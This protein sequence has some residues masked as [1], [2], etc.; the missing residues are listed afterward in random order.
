MMKKSSCGLLFGLWVVLSSAL[1]TLF[2]E[3][4]F[5]QTPY[6]PRI[7]GVSFSEIASWQA[8]YGGGFR[9]CYPATAPACIVPTEDQVPCK[10]RKAKT[11]AKQK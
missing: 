11:R 2:G 7:E 4:V 8:R 9:G 1:F 3:S 5:A 10:P 6:E